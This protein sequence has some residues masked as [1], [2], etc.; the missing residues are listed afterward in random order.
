MVMSINA[1]NNGLLTIGHAARAVGVAPSALRYYERQGLVSQSARSP[2]GYRLYTPDDIERLQFIRSAQAVG[3]T[4]EDVRML[5]GLMTSNREACKAE[6]RS[7]IEGRLVDIDR[8]MKDLKRVRKTLG[9]AL[10]RCRSSNGECAVL[11]ELS[12]GTANRR[13]S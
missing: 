13:R 2:G 7:L 4:L 9:Q 11:K 6:V 3:F 12:T 8:K 10:E 1:R 5:L